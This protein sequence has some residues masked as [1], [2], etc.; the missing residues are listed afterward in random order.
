M[1][2]QPLLPA[3]EGYCRHTMVYQL[4]LLAPC[5][6]LNVFC[7]LFPFP[8]PGGIIR[9]RHHAGGYPVAH[10]LFPCSKH[11][12]ECTCNLQFVGVFYVLLAVPS[13]GQY[14]GSVVTPLRVAQFS[15]QLIT[16]TDPSCVQYVCDG[17]EHGFRF[18]LAF[19]CL[20]SSLCDM[21][22]ANEHPDAVDSYLQ[23]EIPKTRVAWSFSSLPFRRSI[24]AHSV[25]SLRRVNLTN[26]ALFC[27]CRLHSTTVSMPISLASIGDT[28]S[29]WI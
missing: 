12:S 4:I 6:V 5:G 11:F 13:Y 9:F 21:K 19:V 26:G 3:R 24:A 15:Q 28:S 8:L 16:Q 1:V 18:S 17:I 10:I 2:S 20:R 7:C 29:S 23:N 22:S 27:I 14:I 25:S